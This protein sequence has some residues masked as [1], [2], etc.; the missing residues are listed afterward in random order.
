VTTPTPPI[1]QSRSFATIALI[2]L[3]ERFGYYGMRAPIIYFMVRRLGFGALIC[4]L[5][6]L[7]ALP[8]MRRLTA[9]HHAHGQP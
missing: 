6:A 7:S 8:L 3:W 2:E 1:S 9:T 5:I 4:T